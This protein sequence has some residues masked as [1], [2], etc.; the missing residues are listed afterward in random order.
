[1]GRPNTNLYCI[2][3]Y[4]T[5]KSDSSARHEAGRSDTPHTVGAISV[6][7][8]TAAGLPSFPLHLRL[9][10][11]MPMPASSAATQWKSSPPS[12][13]R[14]DLGLRTVTEIILIGSTGLS[15]RV[16]TSEILTARS[17]EALSTSLPKTG[18]F[19]CPW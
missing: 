6:H 17:K 13:S 16:R 18:C 7:P 3:R 5:Q 10:R 1:M 4:E 14:A 12:S 15:S 9:R 8:R 19:D 11:I 2:P